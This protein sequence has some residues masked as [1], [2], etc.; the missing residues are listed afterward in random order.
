MYSRPLSQKLLA[1][2]GG[3]LSAML[4]KR[5]SISDSHCRF[6][7]LQTIMDR[8]DSLARGEAYLQ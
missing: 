2:P 1:E 7:A 6:I 3:I 4:V 5:D 8:I